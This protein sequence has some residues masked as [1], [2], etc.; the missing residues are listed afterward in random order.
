[1][2]CTDFSNPGYQRRAT[3]CAKMCE[4]RITSKT[5][6]C[7]GTATRAVEEKIIAHRLFSVL[8]SV[9]PR[10]WLLCFHSRCSSCGSASRYHGGTGTVGNLVF[11][12]PRLT[13]GGFAGAVPSIR[14]A[15]PSGMFLALPAWRALA[16]LFVFL[17]VEHRDWSL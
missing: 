16:R 14:S 6:A 10:R 11:S 5:H 17:P 2:F 1:M 3:F 15:A 8:S 13:P 9:C 4:D 7:S 12:D